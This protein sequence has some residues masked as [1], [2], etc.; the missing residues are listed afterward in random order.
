MKSEK[1]IDL[2]SKDE[3]TSEVNA[4]QEVTELKEKVKFEKKTGKKFKF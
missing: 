4:N 2:E 1:L 3:S